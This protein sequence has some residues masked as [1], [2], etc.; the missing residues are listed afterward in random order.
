[1]GIEHS[2]LPLYSIYLLVVASDG[3]VS[4]ICKDR[5]YHQQ[6]KAI[7]PIER[8][9]PYLFSKEYKDRWQQLKEYR[10]KIKEKK[11]AEQIKLHDNRQHDN[12]T[13]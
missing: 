9:L 6:V 11:I 13:N 5:Y 1:M 4:H 7:S 10:E 8:S 2:L 3:G 12:K